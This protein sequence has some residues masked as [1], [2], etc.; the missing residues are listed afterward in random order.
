MSQVR[1]EITGLTLGDLRLNEPGHVTLTGKRN[2]T[3]VVPLTGKTLAHLPST[4]PSST[5]VPRACLRH[6]GAAQT[7]ITDTQMEWAGRGWQTTGDAL[8]ALSAAAR[9]RDHRRAA[10]EELRAG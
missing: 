5:L 7:V 9:A 8:L 1:S 6:G 3:R 10:R 2:K 4:S